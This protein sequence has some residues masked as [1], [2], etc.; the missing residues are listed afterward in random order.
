MTERAKL[1][2]FSHS[3]ACY[4]V[5]IALNLAGVPYDKITVDLATEAHHSDDYLQIN[6]QGFV[7]A[8]EIDGIRLTQ[9]LAIIDYLEDTGRLELR[10]KDPKRCAYMRA[11]TQ[12]VTCD[13]HPVCNR[14]VALH[15]EAI[16]GGRET[17]AT[18]T[19]H[20]MRP[21]LEALELI[22]D[23][24]GPYAIGTQLSQADVVIIPQLYNATRWNVDI[25]DLPRLSR[26]K[27]ACEILPAFALAHPD[28]PD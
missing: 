23:K 26:I 18:W 15:A 17:R 11:V 14:H 13:I 28:L 6:P 10:P 2:D 19:R 4:R 22:L 1:Y 3:S 21:A 7:P 20:F 9:S 25:S 16:S 5:R 8:L 27:K 24:E 12:A